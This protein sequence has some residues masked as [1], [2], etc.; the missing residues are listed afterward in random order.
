MIDDAARRG[1]WLI[2]YTHDVAERPSP[3]GCSPGELERVLRRAQA[4]GMAMLPVGAMVERLEPR[5]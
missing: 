4:A 2:L 3:F 5:R 1:A